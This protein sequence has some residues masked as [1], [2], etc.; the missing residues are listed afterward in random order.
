[1]MVEAALA[2]LGSYGTEDGYML[3]ALYAPGNAPTGIDAAPGPT[4]G[5][6]LAG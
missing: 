4:P 2:E 3:V 1:M 5:V 6:A